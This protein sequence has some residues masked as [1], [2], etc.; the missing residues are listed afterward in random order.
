MTTPAAATHEIRVDAGQFGRW[1]GGLTVAFVVFMALLAGGCLLAVLTQ[2]L[3]ADQVLPAL[4]VGVLCGLGAMWGLRG[5]REIRQQREPVTIARLDGE[6]IHLREGLGVTDL[7]DELQWTTVPWQWVTAV[8]HVG[9]DLREAKL[10][11]PDTP[12]EVLRFVIADDRLLDARPVQDPVATAFGAGLGLTPTQMRTVLVAETGSSEHGAALDW[13]TAHRPDLPV[14]RGRTAPWWTR[15]TP[16]RG[17]APRVAVVGAHGRLGRRVVELLAA[18]GGAAPV[19][20]VRNEAHR[21]TLEGLGAEVRM[22]EVAAPVDVGYA[23]EKDVPGQPSLPVGLGPMSGLAAAISGCAAVV[24]AV[25]GA[26]A[27]VGRAAQRAKVSRLLLV[28]DAAD[29]RAVGE[30]A[31]SGLVWTA[32]R[33]GALTDEPPTGEVALGEDV[34]PGPLSRRDLAEVLVASLRDEASAGN[35]WPIA[36]LRTAADG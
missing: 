36:G 31:S 30:V 28:V 14:L 10:I 24:C 9:F 23:A 29:G 4:V 27:E 19:A 35:V 13:L 15:A 21:A 33:P 2:D 25:P 22:A 26:A 11:G 18:Q 20:V 17:D 7:P 6:G 8:H 32:F 5:V 1:L 3:S 34:V 16:Q 12:F